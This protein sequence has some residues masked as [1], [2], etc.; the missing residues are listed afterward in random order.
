M[1][2]KEYTL[3]TIILILSNVLYAAPGT[4]Y[5]SIDTNKTCAALKTAL[6]HLLSSTNTSYVTYSLVDDNFDKTDLIPAK[7]P[8]TGSVIY[9]KY[10][11]INSNGDDL[12]G[13]QFPTDFC[14]SRSAVTECYCYNKEHAFPK[15]WF[16]GENM[17]PM[18]S[19]IHFIWPSDAYMNFRKSNTPLGYV[20][21]RSYVSKNGTQIGTSDLTRNYNFSG[22]V[23]E[24]ID[25]FKG[26]FARAYLYVVTRYEDSIINWIGRST[27]S[28]VLDGNKYPGLK[29]WILQLCVKWSKLDPP[30]EFEQQRNDAVF[31]LQ[32]NRNPYIDYP[33]WIEKIFGKDGNVDACV[34]T[35]IQ[36]HKISDFSIFPNPVKDA[37]LQVQ[38]SSVLQEAYTV[39]IADV[40]GRIVYTQKINAGVKPIID[41]GTLDKGIY[42]MNLIYQNANSTSAFVKE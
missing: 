15:S 20:K 13:Y 17:Y 8:K 40:L 34:S 35:A 42:F 12:C 36:A 32:G 16:G 18:Y 29:P 19:D 3:V 5:N 23:F 31:S 26:D 10:S 37:L 14:G 39:E 2:I 11:S 9:D 30:S 7:P 25:V 28:D 22:N 27:A 33:N 41:V 6:Y 38:I 4:Y 24:P 21:N 1:R